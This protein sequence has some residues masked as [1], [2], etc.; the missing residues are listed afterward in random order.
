MSQNKPITVPDV[1]HC[2][3]CGDDHKDV[4]FAPF[5]RPAGELTH[6]AKCPNT[7]EPILMKVRDFSKPQLSKNE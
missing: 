2:V 3:R 4:V 6:W 7:G 5:L 1:I